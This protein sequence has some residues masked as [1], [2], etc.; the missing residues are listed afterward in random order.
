MAR[1]PR[2]KQI[3]AEATEEVRRKLAQLE[4]ELADDKARGYEIVGVL[5]KR[6]SAKEITST[7]LK[8]YRADLRAE[9]AKLPT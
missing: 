1:A 4:T 3:T 2:L 5:I 8:Q 9:R 6:A 7:A